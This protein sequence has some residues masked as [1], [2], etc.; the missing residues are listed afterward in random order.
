MVGVGLAGL[1]ADVERR[2]Y[3]QLMMSEALALSV[4]AGMPPQ[5]Q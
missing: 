2:V 4:G 5:W 1:Y 3:A